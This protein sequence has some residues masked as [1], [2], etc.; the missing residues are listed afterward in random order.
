VFDEIRIRIKPPERRPADH[1]IMISSLSKSFQLLNGGFAIGRRPPVQAVYFDKGPN[2]TR[3][4]GIC[5]V[6]LIAIDENEVVAW[7]YKSFD[8]GD[9]SFETM[10]PRMLSPFRW[11][12]KYAITAKNVCNRG[13]LPLI[14][15]Q[16]NIELL[17]KRAR[18]IVIPSVQPI[19]A[20][21]LDDR[22]HASERGRQVV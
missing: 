4:E 11:I 22:L 13:T 19:A 10:K 16:F 8:V 21:R 5:R 7:T 6:P 17:L 3:L 20:L 2:D 9:C 15:L 1:E 18:R 14:A 12:D